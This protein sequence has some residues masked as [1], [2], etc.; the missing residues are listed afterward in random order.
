MAAGFGNAG[1]GSNTTFALVRYDLG[2]GAVTATDLGLAKTASSFTVRA[3]NNLTYFLT[4]TNH[5]GLPAPATVVETLPG[6]ITFRWADR[7]CNGPPVGSSGTV[8]CTLGDVAP[9]AS[10]TVA[11][12]VKA[13]T[14]GLVTNTATVSTPAID[15][16]PANDSVSATIVVT[17]GKSPSDQDKDKDKHDGDKDK[18]KD[19]KHKDKDK[20][21]KDKH[22]DRDDD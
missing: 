21:D 9:G 13:R 3:G 2:P 15:T 12:G 7:G 19:D 18:D 22:K 17:A 20:H 6:A 11:I 8:V 1:Q 4:V 14:A 5:G 10:R 16:Q